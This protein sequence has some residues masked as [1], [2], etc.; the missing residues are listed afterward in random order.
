LA[1]RRST[2]RWPARLNLEHPLPDGVEEVLGLM[3]TAYMA[4]SVERAWRNWLLARL[5]EAELDRLLPQLEEVALAAN[6]IVYEQRQ[7]IDYLYFPLTCV[8]S[9][10][11][12]MEDGTSVEAATIG[13]EGVTGWAGFLGTGRSLGR[14]MVQFPGE[15]LRLSERVL[16][17]ESDDRLREFLGRYFEALL[18]QVMQSLGCNR[19]HTARE[20]AC[21]WLLQMH[22]RVQRDSFRVTHEFLSELL[23]LRRETISQI[24]ADL[25]R[26]GFVEY[27]H[28][29]VTILDRPGLER[30]SCECYRI[31]REDY[32]HLFGA[33]R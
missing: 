17:T 23:G 6:Q 14:N 28:G 12:V 22:D 16:R 19:R 25:Q 7:S 20:R 4:V 29:H 15:A 27:R 3:G 32:V 1:P 33:A 5:P 31:T 21:R 30:T 8:V 24:A 2:L 26:A 11:Q 13:A 9:V 10:L 18:L